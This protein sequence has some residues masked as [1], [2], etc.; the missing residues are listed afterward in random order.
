MSD[1]LGKF[2]AAEKSKV[3]TFKVKG[4][5]FHGSKLVLAMR[6]PVF[7]RMLYAL[8]G[9]KENRNEDLTFEE[10]ADPAAFKALLHFIDTDSSPHVDDLSAENATEEMVRHLLVAADRYAIGGV[11]LTCEFALWN[12]L[13]VENVASTLALAHQHD[14][15]YLKDACTRFI[16]SSHRKKV[17]SSERYSYLKKNC[18]PVF[19]ELWENSARSP[20]H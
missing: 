15:T 7:A 3:V 9:E 16:N 2:I 17:I 20:K 13:S 4:E 5:V 8:P 10:D 18:L 19:V 12:R 14:C 11:K 1:E 6:S